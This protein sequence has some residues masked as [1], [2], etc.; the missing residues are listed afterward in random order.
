MSCVCFESYFTKHRITGRLAAGGGVVLGLGFLLH[1][2]CSSL[3]LCLFASLPLCLSASL[4]LCVQLT[5]PSLFSREA[6]INFIARDDV[7]HGAHLLMYLNMPS[8]SSR[9]IYFCF[10]SQLGVVS[11]PETPL[12]SNDEGRASDY[13]SRYTYIHI[14]R[15]VGELASWRVKHI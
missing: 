13:F 11:S 10:L 12:W 3:P 6:T 15:G 14:S 5:C 8:V 1:L 9:G 4:P 2:T 7:R